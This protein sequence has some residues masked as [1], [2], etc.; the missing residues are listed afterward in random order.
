MSDLLNSLPITVA[1]VV[2][3]SIAY[4]GWLWSRFRAGRLDALWSSA[5]IICFQ[6]MFAFKTADPLLAL[7]ATVYHI[8]L[9]AAVFSASKGVRKTNPF[10]R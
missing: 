1:L 3:V 4:G 2:V 7:V 6:L 5:G 10:S 9:V 8:A